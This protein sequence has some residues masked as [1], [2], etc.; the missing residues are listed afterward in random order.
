ME[1]NELENKVS[2]LEAS[3][4]EIK[5]LVEKLT[6]V[7]EVKVDA[8]AET[9]T[10]ATEVKGITAEDVNNAVKAAFAELTKPRPR[11]QPGI[12]AGADKA[13][14]STVD[15]DALI[16]AN[17]GSD[18]LKA[19]VAEL[20][21]LEA[22]AAQIADARKSG[23]KFTEEQNYQAGLIV[24]ALGKTRAEVQFRTKIGG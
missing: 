10:D 1:L 6:P 13:T 20:A 2:G 4:A 16:S 5:S 14:K 22:K 24:D 17:T 15:V 23:V 8:A 18:E 19:A 9:K 7:A 12:A 21:K 3:L 11:T